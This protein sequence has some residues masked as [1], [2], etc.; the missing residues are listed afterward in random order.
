MT[1]P[2]KFSPSPFI[3]VKIITVDYLNYYWTIY[4]E[5]DAYPFNRMV[6]RRIWVCFLYFSHDWWRKPAVCAVLIFLFHRPAFPLPLPKPHG[7]NVCSND[8]AK[9]RVVKNNCAPQWHAPGYNIWWVGATSLK[10]GFGGQVSIG[11][12]L[13][14][15]RSWLVSALQEFNWHLLYLDH[16]SA[17]KQCQMFPDQV[18]AHAF[19]NDVHKLRKRIVKWKLI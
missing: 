4:R 17:C 12:G 8:Y 10:C 1:H 7:W 16:Y 5:K 2:G 11:E 18:H 15:E 14:D 13:R 3:C 19:I 6:V 9:G